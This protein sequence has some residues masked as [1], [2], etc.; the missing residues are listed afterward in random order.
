MC[1][2][3]HTGHGRLHSDARSAAWRVHAHRGLPAEKRDLADGAS[4]HRGP[5]TATTASSPQWWQRLG[6]TF[7][8]RRQVLAIRR[9]ARRKRPSMASGFVLTGPTSFAGQIGLSAVP[10]VQHCQMG[11]QSTDLEPYL[12]A[13]GHMLMT[14]ATLTDAVHGH[15]EESGIRTSVITFKPV[16]P[17]PGVAKLWLQFQRNGQS[18]NGVVRDQHPRTLNQSPRQRGRQPALARRRDFDPA[19]SR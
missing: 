8:T 10:P 17:A 19:S 4:R 6:Q 11:H 1:T 18:H 5:R 14:N 7:Q 16:L 9:G 12:G 2:R 3:N 15:P 13:P